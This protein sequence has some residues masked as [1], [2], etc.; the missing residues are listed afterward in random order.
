MFN[1]LKDNT[2]VPPVNKVIQYG[3]DS[4]L[5]NVQIQKPKM[6]KQKEP[7]VAKPMPT[8]NNLV[9]EEGMFNSFHFYGTTDNRQ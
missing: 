7:Y 6:G 8:E 9:T 4:K 2:N 5:I 3:E 1:E